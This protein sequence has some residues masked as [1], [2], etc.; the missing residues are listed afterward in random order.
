VSPQSNPGGEWL[1]RKQKHAEN[2]I[3]TKAGGATGKGLS[4]ATTGYFTKP[5]KL[6]VKHLKHIPGANDEQNHRD[7]FDSHKHTEHS[8]SVEK[9]GFNTKDN[10]IMIGVNHRGKPYVLEGNHRLAHAIKHRH[11]HI[12]AEVQYYNGGE[13]VKGQGFHP[14]QVKHL[15]DHGEPK[16]IS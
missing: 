3:V 9:H 11:S 5:L 1:E 4:G 15:H 12:H 13:D 14:D 8:K 10:P 2:N 16:R 6:P 7:K